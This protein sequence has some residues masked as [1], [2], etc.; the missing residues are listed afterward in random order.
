MGKPTGFM[1]HDRQLP[2]RRPVEQRVGD[3]REI[4]RPFA[5][6]D[7]RDQAARCMDCGVPTCHAGCPL[8]N[9][10]PDWNDDVYHG[11]WEAA[12]K[13]LLATNNFPE[14]TGR[15]CPAP[16]EEACVLSINAPAV[17]IE[18]IEKTIIEKAFAAGWVRPLPPSRRTGKKVAVV[19][20]GPSGLTCAQQLNR[21]GHQ[22]TVF[23]RDARPG[24]L[25]RYGIPDFKL[26]KGILD[27]RLELMQ[28]EGVDFR[29]GVQ[30]GADR[31]GPSLCAD[32]DAVVLCTGSTRPR[33]LPIP[34]R[35]LAG[36]HF[37][38][39]FLTGQNRVLAGEEKHLAVQAHGRQV[40][41]IGGGDTGSDC[42]GTSH[43]QGAAG[44]VNFELL[45]QPP[46]DRPQN[47]P[48]PFWPMRLR[49]SSSHEEGG[50]RHWN[51]LTKRFVG[52]NG[53][54]TGIETVEVD[55]IEENGRPVRFE[56]IPG[57]E[58]TWLADLVLLALG[59]TGPEADTVVAQ[60][61]LDLDERGNLHTGDD[62]MTSR[63][64]VFAAGDA[65]SGQSL[66]VWAISEGREAARGVDL[67][68][69][70][71]S[72]LPQKEGAD[73]PRV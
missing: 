3:F 46:V 43:R 5:E 42:I 64:G 33:D 34:G 29:C 14:F 67:F 69:M 68:L 25:L 61:D 53:R 16:C 55:W 49:T 13:Q 57:S 72:D 7:L 39:E 50:S 11:R 65:R 27:R 24:G 56:E 71:R 73:L 30:A 23:E 45:P 36:I 40:V 38:M 37:A 10:I 58:K 1:E 6:T 70:G 22:V 32:F 28:Q 15:L 2:E 63:P 59:F 51:I 41:V 35:E 18:Q 47:Q 8:G 54:V 31:D 44:V 12:L 17:T 62:Y 52:E 4:Y 26:E 66:I 20:S 19:G 48:W 21:A 60:L 9:R